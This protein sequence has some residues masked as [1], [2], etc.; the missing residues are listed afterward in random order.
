MK[1]DICYK[2]SL[3]MDVVMLI[4]IQRLFFLL[5]TTYVDLKFVMGGRPKALQYDFIYPHEML[6]LH[7]S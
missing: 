3:N 1:K 4:H 6:V 7:E 2:S 5:R